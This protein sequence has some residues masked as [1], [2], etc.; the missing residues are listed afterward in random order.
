M[1]RCVRV[2][3]R[4]CMYAKP[5]AYTRIRHVNEYV[6]FLQSNRYHFEYVYVCMFKK[7][8]RLRH[9]GATF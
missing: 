8:Q 6:L 9:C 3:L 1:C 2:C 7:Q 5:C 4:T